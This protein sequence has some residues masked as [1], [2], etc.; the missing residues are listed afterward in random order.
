MKIFFIYDVKKYIIEKFVDCLAY[1]TILV[2]NVFILQ[3]Y[4]TKILQHIGRLK[5][6]YVTKQVRK[7][8]STKKNI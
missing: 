8:F 7:F 1:Y 2:S 3:M 6:N 4:L 5:S